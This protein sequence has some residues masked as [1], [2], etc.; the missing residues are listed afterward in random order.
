MTRHPVTEHILAEPL[1][2]SLHWQ[3]DLIQELHIRWSTSVRRSKKVSDEAMQ[4]EAALARYMAGEAPDWPE[5][6]LNFSRLSDFQKNALNA[7]RRIPS[8]AT[9]TYGELAALIGKPN[10]AQ[11]IGR[12]MAANPFPLIYP[13]HR[14][15]GADGSMT[16]FSAGDGVRLKRFLLQKEGAILA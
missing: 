3:D 5:L 7:L 4:L 12:A 15:I 6:P 13:C 16:G 11:A 14:V 2:L 1:A 8:G 10:G 9:R